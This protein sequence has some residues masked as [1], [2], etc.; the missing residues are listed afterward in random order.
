VPI[1]RVGC[2][3][4]LAAGRILAFAQRCKEVVVTEECSHFLAD[5]VRAL[6]I[7]VR[8]YGD[9]T[10]VGAFRAA[11]LGNVGL[12]LTQRQHT[13]LTHKPF[14]I[15]LVAEALAPPALSAAF[16]TGG[17]TPP[18]RPPGFCA[19]CSH[20][21]IFDVLRDRK[22]YVVGDIGCYTLGGAKPFGA[23][24]SN[25]CM[26]ASIGVLQGYLLAQPEREAD[27]LAV[28]GD[29]TFFHSG[30]PSL[31]T[32]VT[33]GHRGTLLILD[34]AGTA[35]TGFQQTALNL[36]PQRWSD[37]LTAVGVTSFEVIPALDIA[38]INKTL[39]ELGKKD[40]FKVIVLKGECVQAR[41]RKGPTRYRYTI[42]EAACTAC[43]IC[44]QRTNCPSFSLS[45]SLNGVAKM[46]IGSE[47]IGC[48]LCSQTC[49]ENAIVPLTVKTGWVPLDKLLGRVRWHRIIEFIHRRPALRRLALRFENERL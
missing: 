7:K 30:I 4:P 15:A 29:S 21:G 6:G 39:D 27:V 22:L 44:A 43:G 48:G 35:M 31:I 9:R 8:S 38:I 12:H 28:I 20:V 10:Q 45:E 13:A 17:L 19:G 40:G 23:L 46:K 14:P 49:P 36:S 1:L 3:N 24:H 37:L 25:L 2:S 41:P 33:Q 5:R 18:N 11:A 47:C 42:I 16:E 34:N 26:A 32:A